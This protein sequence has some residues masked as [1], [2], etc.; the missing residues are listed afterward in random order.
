MTV[1]F[2]IQMWKNFVFVCGK[3]ALKIVFVCLN[4]YQ[5][6]K[7]KNK[8]SWRVIATRNN[9]TCFAFVEVTGGDN[10]ITGSKTTKCAL[11]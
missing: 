4:F 1:V 10:R 2:I 3:T 7:R 5:I 11:L 9:E 6:W 8:Q